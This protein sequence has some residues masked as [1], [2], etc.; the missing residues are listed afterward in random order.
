M[1]AHR[2]RV[3]VNTSSASSARPLPDTAEGQPLRALRNAWLPAQPAPSASRVLQPAAQPGDLKCRLAPECPHPTPP[4]RGATAQGGGKG[5]GG[6]RFPGGPRKLSF[7]KHI[8]NP[9]LSASS[10][11]Q[12]VDWFAG[13]PK[14]SGL[15]PPP[16]RSEQ[17]LWAARATQR[18]RSRG[19]RALRPQLAASLFSEVAVAVAAQKSACISLP[20][21]RPVRS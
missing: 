20:L 8:F 4:A 1:G 3:V 17:P 14:C 6:L 16:P 19:A 15:P 18:S 21:G 5:G 13:S 11:E 9:P 7:K 10:S 2:P 12:H